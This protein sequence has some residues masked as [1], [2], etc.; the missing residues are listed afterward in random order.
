MLKT[1]KALKALA[2]FAITS[3]AMSLHTSLRAPRT[4]HVSDIGRDVGLA[5]LQ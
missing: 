4:A 1:L 5:L 3:S 2:K